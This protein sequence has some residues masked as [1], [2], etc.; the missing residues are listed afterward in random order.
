MKVLFF[1]G[2]IFPYGSAW[3]SRGRSFVKLFQSLNYDVHVI[4]HL[5][6]E[7]GCEAGVPFDYDGITVQFV[8]AK[9][10]RFEIFKKQGS[11]LKAIKEYIRRNKVDVV[12]ASGIPFIFARL[13]RY[14]KMKSI[15]LVLEQC[16]W[17]DPSTFKFGKFNPY[18][19]S[20]I[21][22][23]H[24][25]Y[26]KADGIIAISTLL[27]DHFRKQGAN[28]IRIPAIL[29]VTNTPY[30]IE[31]P[32]ST[33][34]IDLVF[35][36]SINGKKE[37]LLPIL[38]AI[39]I[40]KNKG[41]VSFTII[42]PSRQEVLLNI[43]GRSDLLEHL[44]NEVKI[45]GKVPQQEIS[46]HLKE[47]DFMIFLRPDRESSHAGFPTKLAE[48]MAVGTPVITNETGDINLCVKDGWNGIVIKGRSS[49]ELIKAFECAMLMSDRNRNLM[50]YNARQTAQDTF[51]FRVYQES[52]MSLLNNVWEKHDA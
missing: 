4:T 22:N 11:D 2:S 35:S 43:D 45:L 6:S 23:I 26:W 8:S 33:K 13:I 42:G 1:I 51:D 47:K 12:F 30:N 40:I 34:T 3:A 49:E 41:S 24:R 52:L 39:E 32:Y 48:S 5:T 44:R 27:T 7:K 17:F 16:E 19:L 38:E 14:L 18:Y 10:S 15:P 36:G 37:L 25:N 28:V 46:T 20:V 9:S 50:R 29:D 31:K 21:N